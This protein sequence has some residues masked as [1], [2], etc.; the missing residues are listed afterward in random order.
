MKEQTVIEA[1]KE[2]STLTYAI[3]ELKQY[4][5]TQEVEALKRIHKKLLNYYELTV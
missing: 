5:S 3:T 4:L 2:L 1:A